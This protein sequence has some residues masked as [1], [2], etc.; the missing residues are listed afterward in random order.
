MDDYRYK[1]KPIQEIE[2]A[3]LGFGSKSDIGLGS[4]S[5]GDAVDY[6]ENARRGNEPPQ[7][8]DGPPN[9]SNIPTIQD[10]GGLT[11][12]QVKSL[13]EGYLQGLGVEAECDEGSI[14]VSLTGIP[15]SE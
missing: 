8:Q 6:G 7:P 3:S 13:I 1:S 9:D 11:E 2:D 5:S 4:T 12:D 10:L 15:A 14:T